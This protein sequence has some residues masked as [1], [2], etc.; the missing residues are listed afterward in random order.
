MCVGDDFSI[1]LRGNNEKITVLILQSV[2]KKD[3]VIDK[4]KFQ[5]YKE[6]KRKQY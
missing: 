1:K 5:K 3:D 6:R 2:R 4:G